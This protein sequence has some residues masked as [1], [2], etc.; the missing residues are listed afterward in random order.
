MSNPW[1]AT[2]RARIGYGTTN[3]LLYGTGGLAIGSV[4]ADSGIGS[5]TDT[6]TGWVAGLGAEAMITNRTTARVEYRYTDLGTANFSANPSIKYH[7]SDV[8]VGVGVK[9]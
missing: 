2:L 6:K 5:Q 3:W 7:S 1:D 8:L 9:F 4:K